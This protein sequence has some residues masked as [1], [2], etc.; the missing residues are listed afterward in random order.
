MA[1]P[2]GPSRRS[3][4]DPSPRRAS[5]SAA[6]LA[7]ALAGCAEGEGLPRV[8]SFSVTPERVSPG[9][10][11]TLT[12][13]AFDVPGV[14][15]DP[16]VGVGPPVGFATDRPFV[17]T[18]YVLSVPDGSGLRAEA[19]VDVTGPPRVLGFEAEPRSLVA[20][21]P[22]RLL[23]S[24]VDADAA[25]IT[26]G[27][28]RV[29]PSGEVEV[30]P[31]TTTT[32]RVRALRGDRASEP[33][34][35]TVAVVGGGGP[36]I[37]R[38]SATPQT[39]AAGDPVVLAWST[40][41]A[42]RV[43]FDQGLGAQ[44]PAGQLEVLPQRSTTYTV[45][46]AGPGGTT[47]ASVTVAVATGDPPRIRAFDADPPRVRPGQA[48][49]LTWEVENAAGVN[50][51]PG[52]GDQ[53]AKG[54]LQVTP[55][56]TTTYVLTAYGAEVE[57]RARATVE[58][59]P[60]GAPVIE[61]LEA[62]PRAVF[63]GSATEIA[64]AT[65]NAT[66]V[67]LRPGVAGRLP[68]SGSLRLVPPA[69][70][71]YTLVARG[72]GLEARADVEVGV[73][74]PPPVVDRFDATP[75]SIF[76]GGAAELAWAT[77]NATEVELLGLGPQP[78]S[79]RLRVRPAESRTYTLV[80]RSPA[81]EARADARVMVT[82]PGAPTVAR[83]TAT[84]P[85]VRP[86]RAATLAWRV[87]DARSVSIDRG[88]GQVAAAGTATVSP[89]A[90][91]T[92][93][94]T[95]EGPGG[96]ATA[97]RTVRVVPLTGD[98]CNEAFP[99][100][101]SGRFSG[102]ARTATD[103]YRDVAACTGHRQVGP[104]VVYRV[105]LQAGD[106]L[107]AELSPDGPAY[108]QSLYLL[109]SCASPGR[110]C[111]AGSDAGTP[112]VVDFTAP[113]TGDYFLVVD[114]YRSTAGRYQLDV[115]LNPV[116]IVNDTCGGAIDVTAGGT[117]SGDTRNAR[118]DYT[119]VASAGGASCTGYTAAGH[120]V[121]YAVRLGPGERVRAR[122]D[123]AWDASLYLVTDC[124]RPGDTCVEGDDSGH[125]EV[126]DYTSPSGGTYHLVVDGYGAGRGP[127][128]L[129][130]R[131]SPPA[132]GGDTCQAPVRVPGAGAGFR[133]TT[134]GMQ[135][136]YAAP[137]ACLPPQPGADRVYAVRLEAGDVVRAGASFASGLDGSLYV[138]DDCQAQSCVAGSDRRGPGAPEALRFV[139]RRGGD[140][141]VVADASS[142]GA[143]RH[144]LLVL[145]S[146]GERCADAIPLLVGGAGEWTTTAGRADD[147]APSSCLPR[148]AA[149]PDRVFEV[150]VEAGQQLDLE[151]R[152][153]SGDP[154]VY[155]LEGCGNAGGACLVG[156]DQPG[157]GAE[158]V[159]PVFAADAT[160]YVVVDGAAA[161]PVEATVEARRRGGDTCADPYRVPPEGGIFRGT[162]A[163]F[164]A[165]LG[166][167]NQSGSCTGYAQAGADAVY[168]VT[169]PAGETVEA[170]L[171]SSWDAALYL[172]ST[173]AQA[174]TTC[175]AGDDAGSPER[176]RYTNTTGAEQTWYL[177]VDAWRPSTSL[178]TR[179]GPYALGV[180][181]R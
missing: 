154:A 136:V 122:L 167:P 91:T 52:L 32:Y 171:A 59:A 141:F 8:A 107:R 153:A 2:T 145:R 65:E 6:L 85:Q 11:V 73:R 108:D 102:D 93:T 10:T 101:S 118:D 175:L 9:D 126:V 41:G 42:T 174:A 160:V 60:A 79:G 149:G 74:T 105:P 3:T 67:E 66:E 88:I 18:T 86:G 12:W 134:S 163:S 23:W 28:G 110:S 16:R 61:R 21:A 130:V 39:V 158:R 26:P 99:I 173:C 159:A 177:V 29:G 179:E 1:A 164:S 27:P 104:D 36:R 45:T 112:E 43:S 31:D 54:S 7:A 78:V 119:P 120:D 170:A 129:E 4:A 48:A 75:P 142:P 115:M 111:V 87:E 178:Q 100:T 13:E 37:T 106:R 124:A 72:G 165:D 80:A 49:T 19:T 71:T 162:T 127:F 103:D 81:G 83:F 135:D 57:T 94:L 168:R 63:A 38:L 133:S 139:A 30:R 5:A 22:A 181:V 84:P 14:A 114:A 55:P 33:R 15:I 64:W 113:A 172:V 116:P 62:R 17:T 132:R 151:V 146:R 56:E 147:L 155:V 131:V 140:H 92:Y 96:R 50:L 68:P 44:P 53:P 152:P 69:T 82:P 34:A 70:T 123:A 51:G 58:V 128:D 117:W 144:D 40:E 148:A 161:T 150:E 156:A 98:T 176:I 157:S 95:A 138:L 25:E 24:T 90:D 97:Q 77:Q 46:A 137:Q 47:Q 121:T 109:S 143:G 169:V 89:G 166:T 35:V 76:A 180:V 20:G 125:P